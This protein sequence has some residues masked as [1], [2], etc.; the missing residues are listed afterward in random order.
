MSKRQPGR[1]RRHAGTITRAALGLGISLG[2]LILLLQVV[3]PARVWRILRGARGDLVL[4]GFVVVGAHYAAVGWRFATFCHLFGVRVEE[5]VLVRTGIVSSAVNRTIGFA[6]LVVHTIRIGIVRLW[7]GRARDVI[8]SAIFNQVFQALLTPTLA[9]I[10]LYLVFVVPGGPGL[11]SPDALLTILAVAVVAALTVLLL[12]GTPLGQWLSIAVGRVQRWLE[13]GVVGSH[14]QEV[15]EVLVERVGAIRDR[16]QLL[17][18]PGMFMVLEPAT[19]LTLLFFAFWAIGAPQPPG[20]IILAYA[21]V[22]FAAMFT[23]VP[24]GLGIRE[25]SMAGVLAWIGV[26][27]E[28]AVA[29]VVLYRAMIDWAPSLLMLP[30]AWGLFDPPA[31]AAGAEETQASNGST[32]TIG[33][34]R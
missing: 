10:G 22:G 34:T 1:V 27:W 31:E 12:L 30:L 24:G 13:E 3:D 17:A 11:I 18:R 29:G 19:S 9:V 21:A 32:G 5:G 2:V 33:N 8:A 4:A 23:V 16:P 25:G 7:G 14:V 6:G 28:T 15:H 26:P 20:H